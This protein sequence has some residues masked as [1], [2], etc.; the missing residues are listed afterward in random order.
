MSATCSLPPN[1]LSILRTHHFPSHLHSEEHHLTRP[2][3]PTTSPSLNSAA[4]STFSGLSTSGA[5]SICH[6][7]S[8]VV[9]IVYAGVQAVL[10]RSRQTSPVY[11]VKKRKVLVS[12][13]DFPFSLSEFLEKRWGDLKTYLEPNIGSTNPRYKPHLWR[14]NW[15]CAS[16]PIILSSLALGLPIRNHYVYQPSASLITT[17]QTLPRKNRFPMEKI[18]FGDRAESLDGGIAALRISARRGG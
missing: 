4:T 1:H 16:I 9:A 2:S 15:I 17:S 3:A 13:Y 5:P 7:A 11:F 12:F 10:R 8:I 14:N 6:I 18:V